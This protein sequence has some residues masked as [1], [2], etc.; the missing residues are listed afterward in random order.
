MKAS[1]RPKLQVHFTTPNLNLNLDS[2][3]VLILLSYGISSHM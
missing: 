3:L 1:A 2:D